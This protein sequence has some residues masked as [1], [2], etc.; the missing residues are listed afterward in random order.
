VPGSAQKVPRDNDSRDKDKSFRM[1]PILPELY[2]LKGKCQ[3]FLLL[4]FLYHETL[5]TAANACSVTC[6]R[7]HRNPF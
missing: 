6:Q 2:K 4:N 1:F 7:N 5:E 3:K